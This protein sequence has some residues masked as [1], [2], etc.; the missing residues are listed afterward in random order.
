[1]QTAHGQ[2]AKGLDGMNLP[3]IVDTEH[4]SSRMVRAALDCF[5]PIAITI[6]ARPDTLAYQGRLK[7]QANPSRFR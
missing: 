5:A 1:M 3:R 6:R 7:L 4:D 2:A